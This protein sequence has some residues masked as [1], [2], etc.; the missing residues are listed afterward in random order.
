MLN[1]LNKL[2]KS[3]I[4]SF[5]IYDNYSI[6]KYCFDFMGEFY[7]TN[8]KFFLSKDKVIYS[9]ENN[10]YLFAKEVD[11]LSKDYLTKDILPFVEYAMGNVVKADSNHMS[12]VI[13]VFLSSNSIDSNLST[14]TKKY[15]RRKSYMFGLKG[16]ASTRLILFNSSTKEFYYNSDSKE[17]INFY[18]EALK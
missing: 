15:K 9:Y 3:L 6:D 11:N 5:D 14:F 7:L 4:N 1:I 13:T 10:E 2:K 8:S 12:S 18:K 17:I 16:Y